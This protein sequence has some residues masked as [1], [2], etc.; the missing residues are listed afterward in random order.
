MRHWDLHKLYQRGVHDK[1]VKYK[2]RRNQNSFRHLRWSFFVK[3][4]NYFC[5]KLHL[6]CIAFDCGVVTLITFF[7]TWGSIFDALGDLVPFVQFKK[8]EKHPWLSDPFR[9]VA[10]LIKVSF[11]NGCFSRFLFNL[12]GHKYIWVFCLK[13]ILKVVSAI[14]CYFVFQV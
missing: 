11:L 4:V 9:K 5:Q 13:K 14:F 10:T 1:Q 2:Q 6:I 7:E 12:F 3:I 8:R